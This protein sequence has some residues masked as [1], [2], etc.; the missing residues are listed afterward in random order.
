M[1]VCVHVE[2]GLHVIHDAVGHHGPAFL[3]PWRIEDLPGAGC[4]SWRAKSVNSSWIAGDPSEGV[5]IRW[6]VLIFTD[7][8][9]NPLIWTPE[10]TMIAMGY[11]YFKLGD[12]KSGCPTFSFLTQLGGSFGHAP[13]LQGRPRTLG[14]PNNILVR[15]HMVVHPNPFVIPSFLPS[16]HPSI[17]ART[18]TDDMHRRH[19]HTRTCMHI[20]AGINA[21]IAWHYIALNCITLHCIPS[22]HI[23]SHHIASHGVALHACLKDCTFM[24]T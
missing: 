11:G 19:A 18:C 2:K 21:C 7:F 13:Q 16:F 24:Y 23:T 6:D 15:Y 17:H 22:R 1:C 3:L 4:F 10:F 20:H 8:Q 12:P 9:R 5:E 14:R